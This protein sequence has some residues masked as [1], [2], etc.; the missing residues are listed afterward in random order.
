MS[1]TGKGRFEPGLILVTVS[2][3]FI[4]AAWAG[5]EGASAGIR[6]NGYLWFITLATCGLLAFA[7]L[8]LRRISRQRRM[9]LVVE[10]S[11]AA[12]QELADAMPQLVWT[13]RPDGVRDYFN[14]RWFEYTGMTLA[15][16]RQSGW[17][18]VIFPGDLEAY[19][20]AWDASMQTGEPFRI[21]YRLRRARDNTYRWHLVRAMP[22]RDASGGIKRWL[23][24]STDIEDQK[25]AEQLLGN[26]NL[27]LE[28][29]VQ[30]RTRQL[31]AFSYSVSHDLRSPL[32]AISGFA[33]ILAKRHR[34]LL[35]EQGRHFLD[36]IV[37][38]SSHMGRLI[39][40]LLNYSRLGQKA[41][42]LR[43]IAL[44]D[45]LREIMLS[46]KLHVAEL[47]GTVLIADD[48][49]LV[50]GDQTLLW[51]I[52]SN[53]LNNAITY[54]KPD[55]P[56]NINVSWK[57]VEGAVIVSV[58]DNGIGIATEHFEKIFKV[59]QR[60]HSKDEIAGTG[61]GL[62]LVK[63]AV[64]LL[65]GKISVESSVG[66]GSTFHVRLAALTPDEVS[67]RLALHG[68]ITG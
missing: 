63:K 23:G 34:T 61:I 49:P 46:L 16:A 21:E 8:S 67:G 13:A 54:R 56:P 25:R 68:S 55:L 15:L 22:V 39:D 27:E 52:F 50:K 48:L 18:P 38:A 60:L 58:A 59:F 2:L 24:T 11:E 12:L 33:E 40:D 20:R 47:G 7:I 65:G 32:R 5:R 4:A 3:I 36:N 53:L 35:D 31:E 64:D 26:L 42:K 30:D 10:T 66:S 6:E 17:E 57:M 9:G 37:E 44:A 41:I 43:P 1:A 28:A 62:A 45:V 19:R 51:Q 29:R 14:Q